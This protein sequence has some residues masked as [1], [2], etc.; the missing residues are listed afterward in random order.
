METPTIILIVVMILSFS[1][2]AY[3]LIKNQKRKNKT[4]FEHRNFFSWTKDE[5]ELFDKINKH[6]IANEVN[7]LQADD[8]MLQLAKQRTSFW[9]TDEYTH[10]DNLHDGFFAHRQIYMDMGLQNISENI[11]FG[12]ENTVFEKWVESKGHNKNMIHE[13]WIYCGISIEYNHDNKKV[14]C[15]ILAR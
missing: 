13:Q 9:I 1:L 15:L 4:V 3:I 8:H 11:S 5:V 12:Y 10:K 2:L 6:R 14:V 7:L